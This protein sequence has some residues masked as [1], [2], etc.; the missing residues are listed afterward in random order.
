MKNFIKIK[1]SLNKR[2]LS[3]PLGGG[4]KRIIIH[5]NS[6]DKII[7]LENLFN[8][9]QEFRKG[10][11]KT[12]DVQ[13]FER[14]LEDN[15]FS[16]HNELKG[17]VYSCGYYCQF[18]ITDPK[19]RLI[20]KA[21]VRDRLLHHAIHHIL[22]DAFDK[23]FI[24]DSYSC[25]KNKGTHK[26][27]E[28]LVMWTRKISKNYTK[29]CWALKCDIRKFFDSIDHQILIK[30]LKA[31]IQDDKVVNLLRQ[32]IM[33]FQISPGKG[34]PLGNLTSQLLVNIYLDPL[35]KFIKHKLKAKYYLRY[36]DDFIFIGLNP[37]KLLGFF[38]EINRFLKRELKLHLHPGKIHLRKLSWGI[39]FVGYVALPYYNL[40]RKKTVKRIFRRI[41]Y[42][43]KH[44]P[45][46]IKT[47][48]PS[49]LGYLKHI[50]G[51]ELSN[52]LKNLAH[53]SKQFST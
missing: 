33:G 47:T 29:T 26:A 43:L 40:P 6:F 15:I 19:P 27:F 9:W 46:K 35:D 37:D 36:A 1:Q 31:R 18:K 34:L 20:S 30:L 21:P 16:L 38:I 14:Y 42:F 3:E 23:I 2:D 22:Y 50:D 48:L 8:A 5:E 17:S 25:R 52:A 11:R 32:I 39:D 51:Y 4:V 13:I 10:K 7:S 41:D 44:H 12:K 45:E 49:Y 28:R 24:Y 53:R